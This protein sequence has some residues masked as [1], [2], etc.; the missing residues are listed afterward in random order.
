MPTKILISDSPSPLLVAKPRGL[1]IFFLY[2]YLPVRTGN[3]SFYHLDDGN[4]AD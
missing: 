2:E 3:S 4:E 1:G